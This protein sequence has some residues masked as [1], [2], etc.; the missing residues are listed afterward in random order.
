MQ[1]PF[2]GSLVALP[3]PFR[4]QELDLDA[5]SG[6]VRTHLASGTRGLVVSGT[7]GEAATLTP[8]E[9]C[10]VL[11]TT[12]VAAEG[13]LQVVAGVGTHATAQTIE[14][15][16]KAQALGADG[17]LVVTPY[18]NRPSPDGLDLHFSTVA[19]AVDLPIVL[20]NVPSRTAVDLKPAQ[21]A[22]LAQ[23]HDN[24]VAIKEATTS[25][26]RIQELG[27]QSAIEVLCGEDTRMVEFMQAGAV[28]AVNFCGNVLPAEVVALLEL[29]SDAAESESAVAHAR[30]L[31]A[32]I[33][34]LFLESNPGP[35]KAALAQLG[36]CSP[37]V[38]PPL[39]PLTDRN[40]ARLLSTLAAYPNLKSLVRS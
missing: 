5:L 24:I 8:R 19:Q 6:L 2:H 26:E 15:A 29:A 20:Y 38:R 17:L 7:T 13:K 4:N 22:D 10:K 9:R 33:H 18:Y 32:L 16:L 34:C 28:G 40:R 39:A 36:H 37:E 12:L 3:T 14:L 35:L 21:A 11:E 27:A 23:R 30:H 25:L 31:E 1:N